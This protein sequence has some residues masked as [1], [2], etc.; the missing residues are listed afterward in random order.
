MKKT[1]SN[2]GGHYI[3]DQSSDL[4]AAQRL[5]K[6]RLGVTNQVLIVGVLAAIAG[7]FLHVLSERNERDAALPAIPNRSGELASATVVT[8]APPSIRSL[9]Q[10]IDALGTLNCFEEIPIS[11]KVD[12]T[13]LK[14]HCDESTRV[15]PGELLIEIDPEGYALDVE[16]AQRSLQVDLAK[17]GL[18]ELPP[19]DWDFT[20]TPSVQQAQARLNLAE[21]RLQRLRK[22]AA[23]KA[24][25]D[26]DLDA[27][28]SEFETGKAERDSQILTAN[29]NLA[30]IQ[31]KQTTMEI[32]QRKL[33]DT[34]IIA[35]TPSSAVPVTDPDG[36]SH[37]LFVVAERLVSEGA[38]L[39]AGA[40]VL[41]LVID[42]RLKMNANLP[43][44]FSSLVVLG[45]KASIITAAQ[46]EPIFGLVTNIHP[47]VDP[48]NRTFEIEI[49]VDNQDGRLKP[50]NFAKATI[51]IG[52]RENSMTVP[53]E[54]I[55]GIAGISKLFVV[56]E[57]KAR[58]Y[59]VRLGTQ[60]SD[61]SRFHA[62]SPCAGDAE[63]AR[64]ERGAASII[65]IK[66]ARPL[67][68]PLHHYR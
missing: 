30:T 14:V 9:A 46:T 47:T 54:S 21:N 17:L 64:F 39:R 20:A 10:T 44:K 3:A 48:K 45:Q 40:Q 35:P 16:Q 56:E 57:G 68:P 15:P 29:A 8:V 12:G 28:I 24:A 34:R 18:R 37:P 49:Q 2:S 66:R 19:S 38:Y 6:S 42:S 43:E 5:V 36:K 7:W 52:Q 63:Y 32:A 51:Q 58:E 67:T 62:A 60:T 1:T 41:K 23:D 65:I 61:W 50:G 55:V 53:L 11:T 4:G 31:L 59:Q 33:K 27:A 26:A 22:L 25:S 13:V